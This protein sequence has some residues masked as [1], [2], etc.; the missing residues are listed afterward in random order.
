[1]FRLSYSLI[2]QIHWKWYFNGHS[3]WTSGDMCKTSVHIALEVK[4]QH[5]RNGRTIV[6]RHPYLV[7]GCV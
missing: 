7:T 1:M 2:K 6:G 4:L 5:F 3:R